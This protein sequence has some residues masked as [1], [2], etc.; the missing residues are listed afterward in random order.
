MQY[1]KSTNLGLKETEAWLCPGTES[2]GH[3][4]TERCRVELVLP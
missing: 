2:F 3:M 4:Q 1:W